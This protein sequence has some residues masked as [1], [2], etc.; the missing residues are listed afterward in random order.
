MV[1]FL[2]QVNS[3]PSN[4]KKTNLW[5][6]KSN[7][8]MNMISSKYTLQNLFTIFAYILVWFFIYLHASVCFL[9]SN[10]SNLI[11]YVLFYYLY[12]YLTRFHLSFS[13]LFISSHLTPF[14]GVIKRSKEVYWT[15]WCYENC[16]MGR[17]LMYFFKKNL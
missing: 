4:K 5:I 3:T 10:L 6:N 12:I 8:W 15:P 17:Y 2:H 7:F 13:Q 9:I 14:P 1:L 16:E 11:S